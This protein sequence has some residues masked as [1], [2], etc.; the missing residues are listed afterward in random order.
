MYIWKGAE[1]KTDNHM[2]TIQI[3]QL[4][5]FSHIYF[6]SL[7]TKERQKDMAKALAPFTPIPP[8]FPSTEQPLPEVDVCHL[9]A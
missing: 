6:R 4:L 1:Y 2:P 7:E 9:H 8:V 3:K 5:T